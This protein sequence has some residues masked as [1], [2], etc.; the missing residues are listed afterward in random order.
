MRSAGKLSG[1]CGLWPLG[2]G[3]WD[4]EIGGRPGGEAYLCYLQE[5]EGIFVC[6]GLIHSWSETVGLALE[7][8]RER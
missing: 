7:E 8:R 1:G 2:F 6:L 3:G 4:R 5:M